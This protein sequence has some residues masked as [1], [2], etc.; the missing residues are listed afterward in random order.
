MIERRQLLIQLE[1]LLKPGVAF[2]KHNLDH[3]VENADIDGSSW[4]QK[5]VFGTGEAADIRKKIQALDEEILELSDLSKQK[6][7]VSEVFVTFE[8]ELAQRRAL[9]A[10]SV[11]G[12]A[13]IAVT[14][15]WSVLPENLLFR[16]KHLLRVSEAPEPTAVRWSELDATLT[17]R[18]NCTI[19]CPRRC[20]V[21]MSHLKSLRV[22]RR[23]K[24]HNAWAQAL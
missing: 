12:L 1:T 23:Y 20:F 17:V 5:L 14:M 8:S 22:Y 18:I 19:C 10:M 6:Y 21:G 9:A 4:W 16:G 3:A 11:P 7:V 2:D 15:G 24:L 13:P